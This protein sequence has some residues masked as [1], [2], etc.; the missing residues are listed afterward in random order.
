MRTIIAL[1]DHEI[2]GPTLVTLEK[3]KLRSE[4]GIV[5]LPARRYIW[6]LILTLRSHQDSTD[7]VTAINVLEEEIRLLPLQVS[8]DASAGGYSLEKDVAVMSQL[9]RMPPDRAR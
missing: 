9:W 1:S 6:D 2:D 3:D 7:S 5:L 8:T 4:L